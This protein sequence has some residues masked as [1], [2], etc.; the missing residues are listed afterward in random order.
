MQVKAELVNVFQLRCTLEGVSG[1]CAFYL[2]CG[3][4]VLV[5]GS[6][7]AEDSV[8]FAL[9]KPGV[10]RVKW[11]VRN[12]AGEISS[13]V[14]ERLRFAGFF[15]LVDEPPALPL[16]LHGV[17]RATAFA[18]LTLGARRTVE[19]FVDP[20]GRLVG[21]TFFG[22]PVVSD[23]GDRSDVQLVA[24]RSRFLQG[25]NTRNPGPL[26]FSLQDG[27]VDVVSEELHALSV[28]DLY[29]LA[30][31]AFAEGLVQGANHVQSFIF[32]KFGAR[33]P[34]RASIGAGTRFGYSGLGTVLHP[35]TVIGENCVVGQNVTLGARGNSTPVVGNNV[36]IAAGAKCIGGRIGNNVVVGAN[37]VVTS[38]VPDNC[39]VAGIPARVISTDMDKYRGYVGRPTS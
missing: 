2:Y 24:E 10:Y 15:D 7:S 30:R 1:S 26:Y 4:E 17:S 8:M 12:P 28:L 29:S 18:S 23:V 16:A 6:Y 38:G 11:F 37:A 14:S 21:S 32:T 39:V 31:R 34:Y 19:F 35:D 5:R 36:Y 9:T 3:D 22:L 20:T 13:G 33:I 27:A 25:D